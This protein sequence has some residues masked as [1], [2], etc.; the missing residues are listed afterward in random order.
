MRPEVLSGTEEAALAFDGALRSLPSVS[1]EVLVVDVGGG[2]TERVLGTAAGR[3]VER[4]H[5]MDI[6]SVRLHERHVRHDPPTPAEVFAIVAD[7][8]A[9][10]DACPVDASRATTVVGVAGT[11]TWIVTA[12]RPGRTSIQII[13]SPPGAQ[14]TMNDD[15]V[16]TLKLIVMAG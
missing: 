16:G 1:G 13:T 4:G 11:T 14:N 15:T 9:A 10:L 2:S 8:D 6:G 7:I 5:S 12:L 3:V